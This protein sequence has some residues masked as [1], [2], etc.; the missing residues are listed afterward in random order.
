MIPTG[1]IRRKGNR[2]NVNPAGV[3]VDFGNGKSAFCGL[4]KCNEE[5]P[6]AAK[7]L[8]HEQLRV[9]CADLPGSFSCFRVVSLGQQ[10]CTVEEPDGF[11]Y[12]VFTAESEGIDHSDEAVIDAFLTVIMRIAGDAVSDMFGASPRNTAVC[13]SSAIE[14]A[15]FGT[16]YAAR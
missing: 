6:L 15:T 2:K 12:D 8:Q 13:I 3:G 1:I 16:L 9:P 4:T 11:F 5:L 14:G 10:N 7:L